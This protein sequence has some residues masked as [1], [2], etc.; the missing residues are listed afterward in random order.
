MILTLAGTRSAFASLA[1]RAAVV[2]AVHV[3]GSLD[4]GL[5][6]IV[7]SIGIKTALDETR[8]NDRKDGQTYRGHYVDLRYEGKGGGFVGFGEEVRDGRAS[9]ALYTPGSARGK[10]R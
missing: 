3:D 5:F 8:T 9:E 6:R 10:G 1:A 4:G 7:V 2:I